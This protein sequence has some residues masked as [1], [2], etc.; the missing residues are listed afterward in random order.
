MT[1]EEMLRTHRACFSGQRAEKLHASET[2]IKAWLSE[3]IDHA[4]RYDGIQTFISGAGMGVETWAAQLVLEKKKD[5]AV[6][7]IVAVPWPGFAHKWNEDRKKE[8][9]DI[10]NRADLLR[11]ISPSYHD[12][13]FAERNRWMVDH[14]SLVIAYYNGDKGGTND[15]LQYARDHL[16]KVTVHAEKETEG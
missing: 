14:S 13:I 9:A 3:Q 7:L 5:T 1:K 10:C 4:I 12:D 16:V 2:E 8:Y 6:H 15:T 11:Y